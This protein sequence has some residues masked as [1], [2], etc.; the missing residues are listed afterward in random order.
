MNPVWDVAVIGAEG[1]DTG[2]SP[3]VWGVGA[4]VLLMLMLAITLAFGRGRG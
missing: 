4:F 2:A 3:I 1:V